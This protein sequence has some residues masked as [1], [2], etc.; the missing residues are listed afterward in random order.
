MARLHRRPPGPAFAPRWA[1]LLLALWLLG[2]LG[3]A[4]PARAGEETS[5][6]QDQGWAM[7]WGG[8]WKLRGGVS[9]YDSDALT[10]DL[11]DQ[12]YYDGYTEL[13]LKNEITPGPGLRFVTHY[14]LALSGGDTR[15]RLLNPL[16]GSQNVLSGGLLAPR[17]LNDR[18]RLLNL[19]WTLDEGDSYV[20]YNRLDRLFL[21]WDPSW[22]SVRV[23]RQALTWGNGLV[24]NP[25]DLVNPFAPADFERDY[26]VGDDMAWALY[27][28]GQLNT[29]EVV[30]VPRRN[31]V[32]D[33]V[34]W[35]QSTVA[36]R[37]HLASGGGEL[38]YEFMAALD[39]GDP[40][41]GAGM[42]GYLG[43]AAWRSDV[44]YAFLTRDNAPAGFLSLVANLDYSWTWAE[45]NYYGL[46][47]F[48][49][50]TL[51]SHDYA[52]SLTDPDLA[53]RLAWGEMFTLGNL[54]L[55]LTG[56]VELH[57]LVNV[58]LT[59]ITNL[60]DPSGIV[61][62]RVVYDVAQNWQITAGLALY[63]GGAGSEYGGFAVP[64]SGLVFQSPNSAFLW[65]EWF[66]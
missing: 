27:Q 64:P 25:M 3:A 6:E 5:L 55:A 65:L 51:G 20:L 45:K 10:P 56:Q 42:S 48:Y 58:Y 32:T 21:D 7:T 50:N 66:F 22:G 47:E 28:L 61:Q 18:R 1:A 30:G 17:T 46:I 24:F 23:G 12:P 16:P 33:E 43:G 59:T 31:P 35:D 62:P 36:S 41:L 38:E 11:V 40:V 37:L 13:R 4:A 53:D 9:L 29:V 49:A 54:Y 19:T 44:T 39:H 63:W 15:R 14:E 60:A 34:S 52:A 57:P 2:A 8:H 26:K